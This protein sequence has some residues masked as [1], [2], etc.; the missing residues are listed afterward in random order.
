MNTG[1]SMSVADTHDALTTKPAGTTKPPV[2]YIKLGPGGAWAKRSLEHGEIHFGHREVAHEV[3]ATRDKAA[4]MSVLTASERR[5][6]VKA[7]DFAREVLDF[8]TLGSDAIWITFDGGYLWWARAAPEVIPTER[9]DTT[10]SRFRR[11]IGQT[12]EALCF[13]SSEPIEPD[14]VRSSAGRRNRTGR[15][16]DTIDLHLGT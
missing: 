2:R 6:P 8:Y 1:R 15:V 12:S 14:L 16:G 4:I 3:A 5:N 11:T 10:G 9:S 7:A 13:R